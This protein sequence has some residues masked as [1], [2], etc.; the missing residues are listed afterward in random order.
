MRPITLGKSLLLP[1]LLLQAVSAHAATVTF[2]AVL[3]PSNETSAV[4]SSASGTGTFTFDTVAENLTY[5]LS[6]TG[7]TSPAGAG[8]IHA[9]PVG[10]SGPV[11]LPFNPAPAGTSGTLS[12]TL[13]AA[14]LIN[15]ATSGI[16]TFSD[17]YNAALANG[18]YTNIHTLDYPGGEIRGQLQPA[19][20]V[21]EPANAL[22]AALGLLA[23]PLARRYRRG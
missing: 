8:H 11:I 13:T 14:D 22:L 23:I 10:V 2:N 7:L 18:L 12:G 15:Q 1:L 5:S 9:G 17:I 20:A 21:P 3:L 19:S 4:I 6:Y 16:M